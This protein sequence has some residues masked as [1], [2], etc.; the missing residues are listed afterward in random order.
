MA[1]V[2]YVVSQYDIQQGRD[3]RFDLEYSAWY[4]HEGE[5]D[6]LAPDDSEEHY[7]TKGLVDASSCLD[8]HK[9]DYYIEILQSPQFVRHGYFNTCYHNEYMGL[10][11]RH[12]LKDLVNRNQDKI[13]RLRK[14]AR[15]MAKRVVVDV[16]KISHGE[17]I[18]NTRSC[19]VKRYIS[20]Y[21]KI[22][23]GRL[24]RNERF[25]GVSSFV[26]FEKFEYD[27][28]FE[29]APR[30]IQHRSFEYLYTLKRLL[31]PFSKAMLRSDKLSS[32][33]QIKTIFMKGRTQKDMAKV[34]KESWDNYSKPIALCIDHSKF[35][36]HVC[37]ELLSVE[38]VF[39]VTLAKEYLSDD[40]AELIKDLLI[41]QCDNK[42][43]TKF[44]I[45]YRVL[46]TR[47][48]GEYTTSDGN[49]LINYLIL[50]KVLGRNCRIHVNGDDSVIVMDKTEFDKFTETALLEEFEQY[51][52]E[53]KIDRVVYEFE[54]ISFCQCSPVL[55]GDGYTMIKDPIRTMSRASIC[56]MEYL[57]CIDRYKSGIGL[58][59][60]ATNQGVPILQSFALRLINTRVKPLGSVDKTPAKLSGNEYVAVKEISLESRM[61]FSMAFDITPSEQI[62]WETALAGAQIGEPQLNDF[63]KKYEKFHKN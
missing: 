8:R 23:D 39:W 27:K 62:A 32:G 42:G 5:L 21:K 38:R 35:D 14:D 58:C 48:S 12:I 31:W 20:A 34:L 13:L 44:K 4:E 15:K 19:V 10:T 28:L 52:M 29:K 30:M 47:M 43:K 50:R 51:N 49:S 33:Q 7:A 46:G 59:E 6:E 54:K 60:L 37:W 45:R 56:P 26:K 16:P 63:I 53:S 1:L 2:P 41:S 18:D 61:S 22:K 25:A 9:Q 57:P 24:I 17:L 36:A 40:L 11:Q 3:L 55:I